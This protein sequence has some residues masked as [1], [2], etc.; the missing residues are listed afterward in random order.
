M[1]HRQHEWRVKLVGL[2]KDT[3]SQCKSDK[4]NYGLQAVG[5]MP[6]R[7]G[8]QTYGPNV[9][10]QHWSGTTVRRKWILDL[11][12]ITEELRSE[13][14]RLSKILGSHT[15]SGR[16]PTER[17]TDERIRLMTPSNV[18]N[19]MS[20]LLRSRISDVPGLPVRPLSRARVFLISAP[21]GPSV[22]DSRS[23]AYSKNKVTKTQN[24]T[25]LF[26]LGVT[27]VI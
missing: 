12:L 9:P 14:L 15:V 24:Y 10:T 26:F 18:I 8:E 22:E 1:G 7:S 19:N 3:T 20:D 6:F 5:I 13:V 27:H 25:A 16:S 21:Q 23:L 17:P 4:T 11:L 2:D